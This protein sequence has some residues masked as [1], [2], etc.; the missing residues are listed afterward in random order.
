MNKNRITL[1]IVALAAVAIV[2]VV[3]AGGGLKLPSIALPSIGGDGD[4]TEQVADTSEPLE[5]DGSP[6]Q[7]TPER[8]EKPE[9]PELPDNPDDVR[10]TAPYAL[11][12]A[13]N[14]R[15]AL[16]V[17]DARRRKVEG[18]F[19]GL[20]IAPGRIDTTIIH[21]DDRRTNLQ[22]RADRA[23]SFE[24]TIDFPTQA[25]FRKG[26]LTARDVPVQ[27]VGRLLRA[28][29][30]QRNGSAARDVDYVVVSKDIIDF[31]VELI[32]Y[33]RIRTPRPRYWRMEGSSAVAI[34]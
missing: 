34:G 3:T 20:R 17:L 25:G 22:V 16:R 6:E 27:K 29:D 2:A 18:V 15:R 21:P 12:R 23:I 14:L 33:M 9:R 30:R 32:A 8:P 5:Q 24:S 11:T 1:V 4:D 7:E 31:D 26:G 28:I 13:P 19:D 10:G